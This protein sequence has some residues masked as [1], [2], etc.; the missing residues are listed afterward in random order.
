MVLRNDELMMQM[1]SEFQKTNDASFAGGNLI[2]NYL[3][4][5]VLSGFWPMTGKNGSGEPND[6]S[7]NGLTLTN[8]GVQFGYLG[9]SPVVAMANFGAA[10]TDRLYR[11]DESSFYTSFTTGHLL[12]ANRGL[13]AGLWIRYNS[14]GSSSEGIMGQWNSGQV[15][16][17]IHTA[18]GGNIEGY[19]S[20]NGTNN[21]KAE[22]TPAESGVATGE[23]HFLCLQVSPSAQENFVRIWV[24]NVYDEVAY[25]NTALHDSTANFGIGHYYSSGSP[26]AYF[27]GQIAMPFLCGGNIGDTNIRRLYYRTRPALQSRALW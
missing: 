11:V 14:F 26:T 8:S 1:E 24:D 23:W 12:T 19:C 20:W 3:G 16:W 15:G 10:S 2:S 21:V 17:L 25:G 22:L 18:A 27:E 6:L 13:T 9:S 5:P 7:G 4:L